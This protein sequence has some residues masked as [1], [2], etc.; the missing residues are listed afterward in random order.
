VD[1]VQKGGLRRNYCKSFHG[2]NRSANIGSSLWA[3]PIIGSRHETPGDNFGYK[4]KT[5]Q[6]FMA[7]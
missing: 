6:M 4:I 5:E 7:E 3:N 2:M 1:K